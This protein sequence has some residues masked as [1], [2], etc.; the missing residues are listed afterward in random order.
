MV[1]SLQS[2][3]PGLTSGAT[4]RNVRSGQSLEK[5]MKPGVPREASVLQEKRCIATGL[6]PYGKR[7][8]RSSL[9]RTRGR[10]CKAQKSS[11]AIVSHSCLQGLS[12]KY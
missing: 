8:G 12:I 1:E 11:T 9:F 7:E 3:S 5:R 6:R 2:Q 4:L 10:C